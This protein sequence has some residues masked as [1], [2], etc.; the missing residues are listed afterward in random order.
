MDCYLVLPALDLYSIQ[1]AC[2]DM[3][4]APGAQ[5]KLQVLLLIMFSH[6]QILLPYIMGVR[7]SAVQLCICMDDILITGWDEA[8][9]L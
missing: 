6:V 9:H 8:E 1:D 2:A 4:P 3:P 7:V 5:A